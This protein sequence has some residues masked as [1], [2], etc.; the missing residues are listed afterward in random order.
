MD[1]KYIR[2]L[3]NSNMLENPGSIEDVSGV[4]LAGGNSKRFG[5]NKAFE[6][7]DGI[8][9]IERVVT[10]MKSVFQRLIMITNTPGEYAYLQI[11][12]NK[13]VVKG[14]G[15]LAGILTGLLN[16]PCGYGFFAACDMPYLN[17]ALIRYLIKIKN[18]YDVIVPKVP[19]GFEPLHALYNK[20]CLPV[21]RDA[22]DADQHQVCGFFP[23]VTVRYVDPDEMRVFDPRLRSFYNINEPRQGGQKVDV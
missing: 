23:R 4:I 18:S 22:I 10:V 20:R 6:K 3:S 9:L 14:F 7:I 11:P 16:I 19:E 12:M 17:Q 5:R 13:D 8:P 15:P 1:F 21:I 2:T